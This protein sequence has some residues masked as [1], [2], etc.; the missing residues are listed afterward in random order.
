MDEG[1]GCRFCSADAAPGPVSSSIFS[2]VCRSVHEGAI[3]CAIV[4]SFFH[5]SLCS[6]VGGR[7]CQQRAHKLCIVC[8]V[9]I[10]CARARVCVCVCVFLL[11]FAATFG[12]YIEYYA[13]SFT[14]P[15]TTTTTLSRGSCRRTSLLLRRWAETGRPVLFRDFIILITIWKNMLHVCSR[16]QKHSSHLHVLI[17]FW[18]L[19]VLR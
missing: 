4:P 1:P 6:A 11:S 17:P 8:V 15:T 5:Y 2:A 19:K 9:Y 7:S 14:L 13:D 3:G 12:F 16:Q 18:Y 10:F